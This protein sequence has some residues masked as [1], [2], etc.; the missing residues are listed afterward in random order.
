MIMNPE[1]PITIREMILADYKAIY[2][3]WLMSDGVSL[4]ASDSQEQ[5]A[6]FLTR[7]PNSSFVAE[8]NGSLV[9]TILS[10]HDG[11][12]GYIHHTA[13][14]P[15]FRRLGIG[16]QLVKC[17]LTALQNANILKC[18]LFVHQTNEVAKAF[19]QSVGWHLR[20]DLQL[21]SMHLEKNK[22]NDTFKN[23]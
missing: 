19:W 7:N 20:D 16:Q 22:E 9:G 18:H 12:R 5:I 21:V 1:R 14:H 8:V 17:A 4:G 11:R 3:L 2:A 15:Q 6:Q 13:V 10:G 23:Q